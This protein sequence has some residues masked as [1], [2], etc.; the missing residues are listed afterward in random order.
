M[1]DSD[2]FDEKL[3]VEVLGLHGNYWILKGLD[4]A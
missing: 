2:G 4:A 1:V 3:V